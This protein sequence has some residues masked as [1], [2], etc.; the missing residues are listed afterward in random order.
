MGYTIGQRL[1]NA[2]QYANP[3]S[4]DYFSKSKD[5][6]TVTWKQWTVNGLKGFGNVFGTSVKIGAVVT[7]AEVLNNALSRPNASVTKDLSNKK[8]AILGATSLFT[9]LYLWDKSRHTKAV[10]KATFN[11]FDTNLQKNIYDDIAQKY[12]N[13]AFDKIKDLIKSDLSKEHEQET[14]DLSNQIEE[15]NK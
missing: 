7:A 9:I 11:E 13:G 4:Y 12:Q 6:N 1:C 2:L 5:E 10:K 8:T 15:A 3:Y 14:L